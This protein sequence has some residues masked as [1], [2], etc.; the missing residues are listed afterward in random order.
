M[1]RRRTLDGLACQP[2]FMQVPCLIR[3]RINGRAAIDTL[4]CRSSPVPHINRDQITSVNIKNVIS[5]SEITTKL[6][7]LVL[8]GNSR[9]VF[10]MKQT[11]WK[12]AA[13]ELR[14]EVKTKT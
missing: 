13:A 8:S 12:G 7:C 4:L 11:L 6:A 1:R 14:P 10:I 3:I 5:L 2:F 9:I